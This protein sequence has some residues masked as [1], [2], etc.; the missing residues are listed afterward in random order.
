MTSSVVVLTSTLVLGAVVIL[1]LSHVTE[2]LPYTGHKGYLTDLE[3]DADPEL[4]LEILTRLGQTI[5]RANDLE[6]SKRGLDLGLSRGF[7]G[8]QAAK[9]LMGLAAANFAGGPGRRRRDASQA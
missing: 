6:N 2:S 5:M 8:S 3:N 1:S 7:S 9:H 4:M